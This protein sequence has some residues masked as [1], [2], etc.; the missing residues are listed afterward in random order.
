MAVKYSDI[1]MTT[2]L[3]VLPVVC[4]C[5]V[6]W[7]S[8]SNWLQLY[9]LYLAPTNEN[10]LLSYIIFLFACGVSLAWHVLIYVDQIEWNS[11][12]P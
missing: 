8:L 9:V 5:L 6:Y 7:L 4:T 12:F 3:F 1:V 10:S 2:W 11:Y